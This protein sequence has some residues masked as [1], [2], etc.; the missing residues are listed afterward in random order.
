MRRLCN[1]ISATLNFLFDGYSDLR[2]REQRA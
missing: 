2:S 1:A